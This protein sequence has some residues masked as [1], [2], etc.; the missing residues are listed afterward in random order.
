MGSGVGA[1]DPDVVQ[2]AVVAQGDGAGFVDASWRT[3]SWV[4]LAP[5]GVALGRAA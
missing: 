1:A 2:A 4:V 3:R 5:S